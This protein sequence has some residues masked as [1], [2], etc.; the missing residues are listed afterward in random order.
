MRRWVI[1]AVAVFAAAGYGVVPL[2]SA[3][4]SRPATVLGHVATAETPLAG[5]VV[6]GPGGAV[7]GYDSRVE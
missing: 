3:A 2:A 6:V 5:A 4:P 7:T 1:G